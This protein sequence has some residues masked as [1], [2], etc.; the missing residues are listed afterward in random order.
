MHHTKCHPAQDQCAH[1]TTPNNYA[2]AA[3]H[4][5]QDHCTQSPNW[6]AHLLT[7]AA[8][9]PGP[10]LAR[11]LLAKEENCNNADIDNGCAN[12][13]AN[14]TPVLQNPSYHTDLTHWSYTI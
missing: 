13:L 1:C 12:M 3:G 8:A 4:P 10:A 7:A 6:P 2:H 11:W 5:A 14:Q 9:C